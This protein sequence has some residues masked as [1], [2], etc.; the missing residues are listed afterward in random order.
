MG[1]AHPK[2]WKWAISKTARNSTTAIEDIIRPNHKMKEAV[3]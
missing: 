2:T 3:D 1:K